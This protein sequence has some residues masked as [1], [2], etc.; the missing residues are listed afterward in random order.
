MGVVIVSMPCHC[1][2]VCDGCYKRHEVIQQIKL[3]RLQAVRQQEKILSQVQSSA[4]NR[5]LG[6]I[7]KEKG[8]IARER[9]I[10]RKKDELRSLRRAGGHILVQTGDAH[11]SAAV[12]SDELELSQ[13]EKQRA[14]KKF[15]KKQAQRDEVATRLRQAE[16]AQHHKQFEDAQRLAK[17]HMELGHLDREAAHLNKESQKARMAAIAEHRRRKSMSGSSEEIVQLA[18]QQSAISVADRGAVYVHARVVRHGTDAHR[19]TSL[20]KNSSTAER[21]NHIQRLRA[22]VHQELRAAHHTKTRYTTARKHVQERRELTHIDDGFEILETIDRS[23]DRQLRLKNVDMIRAHHQKSVLSS[24]VSRGAHAIHDAAVK[25]AFE[26][27]F[28]HRDKPSRRGEVGHD[29]NDMARGG[30]RVQSDVRGGGSTTASGAMQRH[31]PVWERNHSMSGQIA[32]TPAEYAALGPSTSAAV[33]AAAKELYESTFADEVKGGYDNGSGRSSDHG[34]DDSL[35]NSSI[36]SVDS[37]DIPAEEVA[38][39][40]RDSREEQQHEHE[41]N[42]QSAAEGGELT[43]ADEALLFS[44]LEAGLHDESKSPPAGEEHERSGVSYTRD[45][46]VLFSSGSGMVERYDTSE[47]VSRDGPADLLELSD[48]SLR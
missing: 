39:R 32:C 7:R 20:V 1:R 12:Y 18:A 21:E 41:Y 16:I 28:G 43:E 35:D 29:F 37:L 40:A 17:T 11:R 47:C 10:E 15:N 6:T 36:T 34:D 22:K 42:D 38:W 14:Q 25:A 31:L 23:G 13:L 5:F 27:Q 24:A 33:M 26:K 2:G 30:L 9:K 3:E 44:E 46:V 19:D 8:E 48:D 4:Y 45:D